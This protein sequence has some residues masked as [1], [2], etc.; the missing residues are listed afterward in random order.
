MVVKVLPVCINLVLSC[1]CNAEVDNEFPAS[2]DAMDVTSD[3]VIAESVIRKTK[4]ICCKVTN[5]TSFY[6]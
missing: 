4:V 5:F 6:L 3:E 2:D 1:V